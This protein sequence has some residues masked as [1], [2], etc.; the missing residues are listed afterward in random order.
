MKT[1]QLWKIF[2]KFTDMVRK[3]HQERRI[4]GVSHDFVHSIMVA[5]YGEI[6]ADN[7]HLGLLAWVAGMCHST[8]RLF[9]DDPDEKIEQRVYHYLESTNLSK[10]EKN[11]IIEAVMAHSKPNDPNDNPV[12]I[13]L[14]DADRLAC[15]GPGTAFR[16]AQRFPH[17]P[18]FDPRYLEKPDPLATYLKARNPFNNIRHTLEW[19]PWL[20]S[21][22]AKELAKPWFKQLRTFLKGF[23][24]QLQEVDLLP[25][26]FEEDFFPLD[27]QR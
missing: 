6:I 9:P 27:E 21:D 11:L 12:T 13:V 24:T 2:P 3:D 20:R 18:A 10:Q 7:E 22:K 4:I 17:V 15:I 23:S 16:S 5:Q 26:P 14:K 8:D 25:Y 19:E 1:R